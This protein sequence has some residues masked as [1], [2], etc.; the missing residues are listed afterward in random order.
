M[1]LTGI[2]GDT[3]R[4]KIIQ[5]FISKWGLF[6]NANEISRMSNVSKRATYSNIKIL[7][8]IGLL[9]KKEGKSTKY[10]LKKDDKRSLILALLEGEEYIHKNKKV[11]SNNF[12]DSLIYIDDNEDDVNKV[13]VKIPVE[14]AR[15]LG[16]TLLKEVKDHEKLIDEY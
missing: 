6:L 11:T 3:T 8:E 12:A 4:V 16:K 14:I 5:E 7:D 10:R 2:F 9:E 13:E 15:K 1:V